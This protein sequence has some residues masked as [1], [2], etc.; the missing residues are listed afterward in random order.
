MGVPHTILPASKWD[1]GNV[2]CSLPYYPPLQS[3]FSSNLEL[4][5]LIWRYY[6][7]NKVIRNIRIFKHNS[8]CQFLL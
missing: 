5:Y 7:L 4:A 2:K 6:I 8:V 1:C 3:V